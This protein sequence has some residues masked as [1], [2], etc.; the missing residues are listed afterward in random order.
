VIAADLAAALPVAAVDVADVR[1]PALPTLPNLRWREADCGQADALTAL[2]AEYDLGVGALPARFGFQTLRA[3]IAARRPLVDV[4]FCAED[5]LALDADARRAGVAVLP[6]CG[7][8]PG[9][10]NLVLGRAMAEHGTPE[11]VVIYVG[12]V[13]QDATRPYGYEVTWSLDDLLAEY[14]RPARIVRDGKPVTVPV[15]SGL[16]R[17]HIEGVGEMEAFYSDGLRTLIDTVPGVREMGE[18]TLRWP[19]HV[20]A[21]QPLLAEGRLVDEFR[22]RCVVTEPRDVLAFLVRLRWPGRTQDVLLVDRYDPA[23]RL[24]AMARTTALT[25]AVTAQLVAAGGVRDSGVLPLDRVARDE[26]AFRFIV[27]ELARRGVALR[28]SPG[29]GPA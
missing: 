12:G 17:I 6:D 9:L 26:R 18:K 15:F 19:G 7:V 20:A 14:T 8:A 11:E 10:S 16:E 13:A 1:Q 4:S 25:T 27:D 28:W 22:A 2:L 21:V 5:A 24:T 23:S 3:A 29:A